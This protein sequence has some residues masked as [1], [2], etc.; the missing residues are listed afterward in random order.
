MTLAPLAP[1]APA[2][3]R[4]DDL[5]ACR[6]LLAAGSKSFFAASWLL[7]KRCLDGA[8]VLYAFCRIADDLV[9][10]AHGGEEA[11]AELRARLDG[12]YGSAVCTDPIDRSLAF[13][14]RRHGMP[15]ALFDALIEGFAWD[16]QG[17]RYETISDVRAYGARVAGTVGALMTLL[18]GPR[19]EETLAR[20]CDLGV[21]MQLTNIA[22]DIGT[23]ARNDRVYL[24]LAWLRDARIDVDRLTASP[25]PSPELGMLTLQLLQEADRL[26]ARSEIGVARLPEDCRPSIRA[27]R[28]VYAAIGD[29]IRKNGFDSVTRR[30]STSLFRKLVLLA[31]SFFRLRGEVPVPPQP[32][33]AETRFL[34]DAVLAEPLALPEYG[35]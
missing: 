20:A 17:R 11:V 18:M 34:V 31:R 32:A 3:L 19:D 13:V 10:E 6:A 23:D 22:R 8:T 7:P 16:A 4:D 26:Y 15:R 12:I 14:V 27:A 30:A 1:S 9:D 33:L 2:A 35:R 21:A 25:A 24:P 29:V 28:L 5:A